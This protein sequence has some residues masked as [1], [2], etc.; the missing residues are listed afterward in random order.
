MKFGFLP[1][2]LR[3]MRRFFRFKH[4]LLSSFLQPILWLA[5]FGMAMAGNFDRILS[6]NS[7]IPGVLE[8]SYLTF[9]CAGIIG[10]TILFTNMYGGF[11][12]MFDKNWGI[13]REIMASPLPRRDLIIGI[14]SAAITKSW[15]QSA[16]ILIFGIILGVTFFIGMSPLRTFISVIGFFLFV[17]AFATAFLCI[18]LT[19]ALRMDSPEGFQGISTLLTM[20]LFFLSNSLYPLEGLPPLM[21]TIA[22]VNPL[23]HLITGI[24]YCTI[25]EHFSSIG[26]EVIYSSTEVLFSFLYL[27][28]FSI[29]MFVITLKTVEKVEVS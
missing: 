13:L 3:D 21:G 12:L 29:V 20:P 9:M 25:G 24:R 15:I 1:I 17:A 19:L 16:I 10:A 28:I 7:V 2:Y 6:S 26:M 22:L 14:A 18:S 8:V 11:S 27:V 5:F 23:T 4:Q